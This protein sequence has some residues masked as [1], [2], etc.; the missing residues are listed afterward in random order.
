MAQSPLKEMKIQVKAQSP[1]K[2]V[3][4]QVKAQSP[5]KEMK[6]RPLAKKKAQAKTNLNSMSK[7]RSRK[8][9]VKSV[10]KR[11]IP[12]KTIGT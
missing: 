3:K 8:K 9:I 4:I 11:V 12:A 1:L 10:G 7:P 6:E 2:E 5:L